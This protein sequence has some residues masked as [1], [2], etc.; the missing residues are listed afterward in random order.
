MKKTILLAIAALI[1]IVSFGQ[2]SMSKKIDSTEYSI[3]VL[4]V[5]KSNDC[6]KGITRNFKYS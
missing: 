3:Q 4:P 5:K 2:Q 1:G 6:R